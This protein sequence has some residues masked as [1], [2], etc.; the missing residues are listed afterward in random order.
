MKS[1]LSRA[2]MVVVTYSFGHSD[3][4]RREAKQAQFP[5]L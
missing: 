3:C 5:V 4:P 1:A 2:A